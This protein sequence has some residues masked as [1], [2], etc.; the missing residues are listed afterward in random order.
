M[1]E[2]V[3][4]D[5]EATEKVK[6]DERR[7]FLGADEKTKYFIASPTAEDIRGADWAYSKMY[8]QSLVE[9]ITTS[10]EM[11]DILNRRGI[12]GLE[13]EKRAKELADNLAT[14]ITTLEGSTNLEEKRE[15]AISVAQAREELFQWNQRLNG[16]LNNS[17]EQIAD[18][19]RLEFLTS[20]IIQNEQGEKIWD[21]HDAY[22]K[23]K[24]QALAIR[25]RFEVMLF[26][27][28]L[29]SDFLSQTPESVALKEI[30]EGVMDK[31]KETL[32]AL[33]IVEEEKKEMIEEKPKKKVKKNRK[34]K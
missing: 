1:V 16:P 23:E 25:S 27:Q 15:L 17:C 28:G 4:N 10:S 8:T 19:S 12:I 18:D 21:K 22:L 30:E 34:N 32:K 13:F 5:K 20:C 7:S 14:S 3:E 6:A 26:L 33:K 2:K 31:A 11:I 24:N 29:E 9:G